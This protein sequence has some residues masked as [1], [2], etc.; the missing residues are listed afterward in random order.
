MCV[1]RPKARHR[2][3]SSAADFGNFNAQTPRQEAVEEVSRPETPPP[4]M[5]TPLTNGDLS[6]GEPASTSVEDKISKAKKKARAIN[7]SAASAAKAALNTPKARSGRKKGGSL[8]ATV[9]QYSKAAQA[10]F[11]EYPLYVGVGGAVAVAVRVV[12][13]VYPFW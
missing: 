5:E 6:D 4:A 9:R 3:S 13:S 2:P 1:S 7:A 11:E 8:S 10:T 12:G